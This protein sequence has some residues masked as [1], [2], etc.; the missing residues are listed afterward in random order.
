MNALVTGTLSAL[1]GLT[2]MATGAEAELITDPSF[3]R[4][5]V[6]LRPEPGKKVECG[7]AR[8]PA[9]AAPAWQLAQ[10]SSKHPLDGTTP[11]AKTDTGGIHL[12]NPARSISFG[13]KDHILTLA[14]NAAEEYGDRP[15]AEGQPWVHLLVEQQVASQPRLGDLRSL[16]L[17]L[18]ARQARARLARA[19]GHDPK[20]HA[21][22]FLLFLSVQNL[23]QQSPGFGNY[24]WFGVPVFDN[25]HR[26]SET[27]AA[28]DFGGT[29]KFIYTPGTKHFTPGSTHDGDWVKFDADLLPLIREGLAVARSKGFLKGT[30][31]D[32][33]LRVAA[34]NM[35]WEVPGTFDVEMQVRGLSLIA[36]PR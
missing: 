32:D 13:G 36:T 21:A 14:V 10:W 30:D 33:L 8:P 12:A 4:G 6:L 11:L 24:L 19:D 34:L 25:R 9:A 26:S 18:E 7:I 20:R 23:E 15:R 29:G 16:R 27:Y 31:G 22:Q 28:Q 3:Q 35:G 5:F 17:Q 1:A 2:L